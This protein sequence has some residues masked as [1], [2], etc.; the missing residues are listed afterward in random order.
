MAVYAIDAPDGMT[1][2]LEAPDGT[3]PELV[4]LKFQRDVYPGILREK[5][6]PAPPEEKQSAFRQVADVPLQVGAGAIAGVRMMADFFGAG[7]E[8]SSNL[9]FHQS[10][11]QYFC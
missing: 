10:N 4:S 5:N 3:P 2:Q 7:S 11:Q 9:K 8:T 6:K 1:Y